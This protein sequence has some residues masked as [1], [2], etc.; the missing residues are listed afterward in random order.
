[1][2]T[3]REKIIGK[4]IEI[5]KSNPNGIRYSNLVRKIHEEYSEIPINTIHGTV[6]NL[7]TRVP[8]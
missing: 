3:R 7:E 5:I 1:M 4:A 8:N 2:A 6:W